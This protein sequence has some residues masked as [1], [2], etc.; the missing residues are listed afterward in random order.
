M[1]LYSSLNKSLKTSDAKGPGN[2]RKRAC[3]G[4][5]G[6]SSRSEEHEKFERFLI[7]IGIKR[8]QQF[9]H[10]M[11]SGIPFALKMLFPL[12]AWYTAT[13]TG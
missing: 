6:P 11:P 9:L 12:M 5:E 8:R 1:N 3:L 7:E 10:F 13:T 4:G 2:A